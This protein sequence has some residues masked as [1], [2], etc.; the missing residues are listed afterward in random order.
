MSNLFLR[1]KSRFKIKSKNNNISFFL[2]QNAALQSLSNIAKKHN[3]SPWIIYDTD[4]PKIVTKYH[5]EFDDWTQVIEPTIALYKDLI[6]EFEKRL[7]N[8]SHTQYIKTIT[9][10]KHI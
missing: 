1:K 7:S 6:D 9:E 10:T 3:Y 5:L 8:L 2:D 4:T